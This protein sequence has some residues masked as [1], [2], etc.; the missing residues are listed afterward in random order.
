MPF[1][2]GISTYFSILNSVTICSS[3]LGFLY[4]SG[5]GRVP[6]AGL[7]AGCFCISRA[8]CRS[9]L[10]GHYRLIQR[11][12]A[13]VDGDNFK[14]ASF[15]PRRG[16]YNVTN[17]LSNLIDKWIVVDAPSLSLSPVSSIVQI[18]IWTGSPYLG[19]DVGNAIF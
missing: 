2:N 14:Y 9:V 11:S 12:A 13:T 4:L 17:Q 8:C 3:S 19:M 1:I 6:S 7:L 16:T 18:M 10:V 5:Q 15:D